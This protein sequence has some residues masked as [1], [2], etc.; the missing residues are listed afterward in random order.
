MT[1][2]FHLKIQARNLGVIYLYHFLIFPCIIYSIT[3]SLILTPKESLYPSL[4]PVLTAANL[5]WGLAISYLLLPCCPVLH[6][7]TRW[8]L[9]TADIIISS[10]FSEFYRLFLCV[11]HLVFHDLAPAC[12]L[13]IM[14][15]HSSDS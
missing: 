8:L 14:F 1:P 15:Y 2:T 9:K 5:E 13:S 6:I 11:L 10:S 7:V 3:R 4:L 12:M